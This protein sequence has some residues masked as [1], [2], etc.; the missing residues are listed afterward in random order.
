MARLLP[1]IDLMED[2]TGFGGMFG[3]ALSLGD[4]SEISAVYP[5]CPVSTV[6]REDYQY[7]N[8]ANCPDCGQGM[9]RLGGCFHCPACGF[10]SCEM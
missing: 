3:D 1:V 10:S 5:F 8:A 6:T 9:I 2:E 4:I 7:H